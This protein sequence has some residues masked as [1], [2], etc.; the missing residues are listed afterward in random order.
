MR[1][2]LP[3]HAHA[4][5]IYLGSTESDTGDSFKSSEANSSTSKDYVEANVMLQYNHHKR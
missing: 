4:A 2:E 1:A 5:K 3:A